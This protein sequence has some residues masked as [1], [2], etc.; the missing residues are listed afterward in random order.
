M[1][2]YLNNFS[3]QHNS[4]NISSDLHLFTKWLS[5]PQQYPQKLCMIKNRGFTLKVI[6]FTEQW[7]MLGTFPRVFSL[8]AAS[9]VCS[10]SARP[11]WP[12]L[13][14]A[15]GPLCSPRRLRRP[16]LIF[17]IRLGNYLGSRSW[18]KAFGKVP[19]THLDTT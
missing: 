15:L 4:R 8:I 11:P 18:E 2:N 9:Q 14:R 12:I 3:V 16:K 13:A 7:R 5:N 6:S 17:N 10:H 1:K 19:N